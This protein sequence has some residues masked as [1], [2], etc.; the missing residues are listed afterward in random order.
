MNQEI[1]IKS[2]SRLLRRK[3]DMTG[4]KTAFVS[5]DLEDDVF[6]QQLI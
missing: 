6:I 5:P 3:N 2:Q 4:R 1:I